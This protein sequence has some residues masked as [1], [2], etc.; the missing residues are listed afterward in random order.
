MAL[1]GVKD[2]HNVTVKH[3]GTWYYVNWLFWHYDRIGH[4]SVSGCAC[5][6]QWGVRVPKRYKSEAKAWRHIRKHIS[7]HPDTQVNY[8]RSLLLTCG[9]NAAVGVVRAGHGL[10]AVVKEAEHLALLNLCLHLVT[11]SLHVRRQPSQTGDAVHLVLL[12]SVRELQL[13]RNG[14]H[15]ITAARPLAAGLQLQGVDFRVPHSRTFTAPLVVGVLV[16]RGPATHGFLAVP[17]QPLTLGLVAASG[18]K[19][20]Q[21]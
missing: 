4:V 12:A 19:N 21:Y 2:Y 18:L 10:D 17:G 15:I 20:G 14:D 5:G 9:V 8:L 16:N 1:E 11:I 3:G 6:S 7:D 13:L